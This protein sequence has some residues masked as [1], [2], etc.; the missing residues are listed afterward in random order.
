MQ[1]TLPPEWSAAL[2]N[3]ITLG[4]A[5]SQLTGPVPASWADMELLQE[6]GLSRNM[7]SGQLPTFK[8]AQKQL[9]APTSVW[10]PGMML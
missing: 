3:I 8:Y 7:L 4:I 10:R 9:P 1:G 6:M 5:G 2:P